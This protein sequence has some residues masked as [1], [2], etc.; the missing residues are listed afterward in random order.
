MCVLFLTIYF[1]LV[2][3]CFQMTLSQLSMDS[4][5]SFT[6]VYARTGG[7]RGQIVA[8]KMYE[9]KHLYI[10]RKMKKEM[11]LVNTLYM[12]VCTGQCVSGW[13]RDIIRLHIYNGHILY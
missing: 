11:K 4:R 6:Q 5:M 10:S 2:L 9:K 3:K 12:L 8:L 7:Y 13:L 1:N